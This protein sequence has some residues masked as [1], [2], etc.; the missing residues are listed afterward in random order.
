[1]SR[2]NKGFV[3]PVLPTEQSQ[4]QSTQSTEQ[5]VISTTPEQPVVSKRSL[6]VARE[7]NAS[8]A[9]VDPAQPARAV[10]VRPAKGENP[11]RRR[12][13][14]YDNGPGGKV[15]TDAKVVVVSKSGLEAAWPKLAEALAATPDGTVA[16]LKS[17]GVAGKSF[18]RAFRSGLIRFSK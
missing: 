3:A 17:A 11:E 16:T 2:K 4:E 18:R 8:N 1:M 5:P 12:V 15:P 13:F 10:L 6:G 14:G 7:A 9:P